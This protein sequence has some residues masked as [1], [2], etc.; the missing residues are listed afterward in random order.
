MYAQ[1]PTCIG[2]REREKLNIVSDELEE[3][4]TRV[5]EAVYFQIKSK[6]FLW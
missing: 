2:V 6:L 5:F 1:S 3:L 4:M